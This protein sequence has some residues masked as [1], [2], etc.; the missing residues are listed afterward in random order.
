M[1]VIL[2]INCTNNSN[3]GEALSH[4]YEDLIFSM[5]ANLSLIFLS[6]L[7]AWGQNTLS[8]TSSIHCHMHVSCNFQWCNS[9]LL[10]FMFYC[11][12]PW[13]VLGLP[14]LHFPSGCHV[15]AVL[16][17]LFLSM[18]NTCPIPFHCFVLT[19]EL[20]HFKFQF[21]SSDLHWRLHTAIESLWFSSCM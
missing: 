19:S 2:I 5:H 18:R 1:I 20:T 12:M 15:R 10:P 6:Q 4:D 13:L 16:Q 14:R 3:A 11:P 7:G 9:H 21:F 8:P 17:W